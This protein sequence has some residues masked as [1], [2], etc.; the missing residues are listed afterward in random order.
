MKSYWDGWKRL[1]WKHAGSRKTDG[2]DR[3][4]NGIQGP[5]S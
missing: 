2:V 4:Q 5:G 3:G 1:K